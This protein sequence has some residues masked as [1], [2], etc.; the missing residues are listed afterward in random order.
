MLEAFGAGTAAV[1]SPISEIHY[2]DEDFVIPIVEEKQAGTFTV[3]MLNKLTSIYTGS[4][5]SEW[6]VKIE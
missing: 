1:V 6:T 4:R 2:E 3:E 5:S